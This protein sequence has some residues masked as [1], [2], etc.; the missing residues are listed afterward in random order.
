MNTTSATW[1]GCE[2]ENGRYQVIGLLGEGGMAYVYRAFDRA[3]DREVVLKVPKPTLLAEPEFMH[4]FV[5]E[6][7][8]LV[9]LKHPSIVLVTGV[10]RHDGVPFAVLEYMAGGT[11]DERPR[12]V[13]PASLASWLPS[14]A[15]ALDH[16]HAKGF[17]HRD[18]KPA[19]ILIDADGRARLSDFGIIKSVNDNFAQ[20]KALT[21]SGMTVGTPEYM[22][23][24]LAEGKPCS[25]SA[26][27]YALAVTVYQLLTDVM[28]ITGDTPV[29]TLFNQVRERPTPLDRVNP[30]ISR[31][32]AVAVERALEKDARRRYASCS[33]F[34]KQ[35]L[36]AAGVTGRTA[37]TTARSASTTVASSTGT[38]R[39]SPYIWLAGAAVV[40]LASGIG[41]G[42]FVYLRAR[43]D[44]PVAQAEGPTSTAP[45]FAVRWAPVKLFAGRESDVSL[46]I[47][48][49]DHWDGPVD[50]T[51]LDSPHVQWVN[52]PAR[53]EPG[54]SEV[55]ARIRTAPAL[56]RSVQLTVLAA[57]GDVRHA[58]SGEFV[59][60]YFNVTGP[61]IRLTS[62]QDQTVSLRLQRHGWDAYPVRLGVECP[63]WLK[64]ETDSVT[65]PPGTDHVPLR[66]RSDGEHRGSIRLCYAGVAVAELDV[67]SSRP[68]VVVPPPPPPADRKPQPSPVA[69]RTIGKADGAIVNLDYL[70]GGQAVVSWDN[71]SG[72]ALWP[73]GGGTPQR[74]HLEAV[75]ATGAVSPDGTLIASVS[76][77]HLEIHTAAGL[78]RQ[79]SGRNGLK[80]DIL[81]VF[82]DTFEPRVQSTA[83]IHHGRRDGALIEAQ[84]PALSPATRIKYAT[85]TSMTRKWF[86]RSENGTNIDWVSLDLIKLISP[87]PVAKLNLSH[88]GQALVACG[89]GQV[90]LWRG[91]QRQPA[92]GFPKPVT[93][94][95]AVA[96]SPDGNE[97]AAGT[98]TGV[99]CLIPADQ[100]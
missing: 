31:S 16:I 59:V 74:A 53:V 14:I 23:P 73:R 28:P 90:V 57:A 6:I 30:D 64:A 36:A 55:R 67:T 80:N 93:N 38:S 78:K 66:L 40:A 71:R 41:L 13:P 79:A 34:A 97:I 72:L 89:S 69:G 42:S 95:T 65:F 27:Q 70:P 94:V 5:R 4:R 82:F 7:R 61:P 85:G 33:A 22:A 99:I 46:A 21:L 77:S 87:I 91:G 25:G 39:P 56:R 75:P 44:E 88:N 51:F 98:T 48:R 11:L 49:H 2:V 26:D 92:A 83:G 43:T 37:A 20:T 24:E 15:A 17:V 12:P 19:N 96:V 9:E 100:P 35:V 47:E 18:V 29:A 54:Q 10:G 50:L 62:D 63:A 3:A 32:L 76:K 58:L 60:G 45:S 52:T 8:A 1:V 81:A 84:T 86:A 68:A